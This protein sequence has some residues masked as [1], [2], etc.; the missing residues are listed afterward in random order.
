MNTWN[1]KQI[2]RMQEAAKP[3]DHVW[4]CYLSHKVQLLN[5]KMRNKKNEYRWFDH[6]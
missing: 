1:S 6:S 4:N 5:Q 2:C 3:L